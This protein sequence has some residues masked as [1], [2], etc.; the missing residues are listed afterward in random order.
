MTKFVPITPGGTVLMHLSSSTE[1]KAWAKL[2]VDAGHMPY[3]TIENF[4]KRGYV[5]EEI[6][7]HS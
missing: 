2:L 3:K 5:V 1:P 7:A 6:K 4:K